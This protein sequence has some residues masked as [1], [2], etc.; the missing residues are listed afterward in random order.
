MSQLPPNGNSRNRRGRNNRQNQNNDHNHNHNR[1]N[2]DI[3]HQNSNVSQDVL[4]QSL[5]QLSNSQ[6]AQS[7]TEEEL[8]IKLDIAN[9][10]V[11]EYAKKDT[12][13]LKKLYDQA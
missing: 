10:K 8:E 13:V 9:P 2:N 6:Q 3:H 4:P 11:I 7:D 5:S 12:K 1:H